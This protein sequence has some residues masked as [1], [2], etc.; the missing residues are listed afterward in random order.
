MTKPNSTLSSVLMSEE[1]DFITL[2]Q[3]SHDSGWAQTYA[4][5]PEIIDYVKTNKPNAKLG[6]HMTWAYQHDSTHWAFSRYGSDQAT[7]YNAIVNAVKSEIVPKSEIEFIVPSG[8]AIQ[9]ARAS[10]LG[11]TLTRDG[12]HLSYDIGR[13]IAGLSYAR[14]VTGREINSVE[15]APLGISEKVKRVCLQ[16][17]NNA[18]KN[19]FMV[20]K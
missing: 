10:F 14:T 1:W 5:L 20:T 3:G 4:C 18:V 15:F 16:C 9:N 6:W 19:P 12:F 11:D 8:T 7:M 13:Y 17:V 2:Q